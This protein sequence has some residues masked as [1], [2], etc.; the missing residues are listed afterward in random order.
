LQNNLAINISKAELDSKKWT[1][2]SSLGR[3]LPDLLVSYRQQLYANNIYLGG[4][5]PTTFHTPNSV[6]SATL[7][8]YAFQGGQI[9]YQARS[10][11]HQK[12]AAQENL[13]GVLA[14]VLLEITRRYY[15]AV[16]GQACHQI[17]M[18]AIDAAHAEIDMN[19]KREIDGFGTKFNILQSKMQ[20]ARDEHAL[21]GE[22]VSQRAASMKLAAA[23][24]ID[25]GINYLPVDS[26][27]R[28]VTLV[29]PRLDI[30]QLVALAMKNRPELARDEF[31]RLAARDKMRAVAGSV[32]PSLQLFST[33][34]AM[35][36]YS[37]TLMGPLG[38]LP[39]T[40]FLPGQ[41]L[42]QRIGNSFAV[43]VQVNW[44]LLSLGA[45]DMARMQ[46]EKATARAAMLKAHQEV[47]NVLTEVR[48]AYL[49]SVSAEEQIDLAAK[50]VAMAKEQLRLAKMRLENGLGSNLE[51]IQAER[52]LTNAS[53]DKAQSI[54]EFNIAQ[55]QL[56]HDTGLIS[57]DTITSGT[58]Y[59]RADA[60]LNNDS[61]M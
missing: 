44:N 55:A 36:P 53:M 3:N 38:T 14:D 26:E 40:I 1:Y 18:Q 46:A 33:Y 8:Y 39:G 50:E 21:L 54:I 15:L 52:D 25:P 13:H 9:H 59:P 31:T 10:D 23:L 51:L 41:K 43:G 4:P 6:V 56:L 61:A 60:A 49:A 45:P 19:T 35:S 30:P 27:I 32:L 37:N 20:L 47:L 24:G 7:R 57:V 28:K 34:N 58:S 11:L 22:D 16:L 5:E 42:T 48:Q 12:E 2:L 29:D 17:R